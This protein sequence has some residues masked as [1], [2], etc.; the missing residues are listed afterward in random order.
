M[1][2]WYSRLVQSWKPRSVSASFSAASSSFKGSAGRERGD[3]QRG[4]TQHA[5]ERTCLDELLLG[6]LLGLELFDR[7][8]RVFAK[9]EDVALSFLRMRLEVSAAKGGEFERDA[10]GSKATPSPGARRD[11]EGRTGSRSC[12]ERQSQ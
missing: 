3:Q 1:K 4:Q 11:E 9:R 10:R 12:D 8:S 6:S 7:D 5:P 2:P